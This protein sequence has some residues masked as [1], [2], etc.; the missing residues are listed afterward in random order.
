MKITE[1]IQERII[2]LRLLDERF[3]TDIAVLIE[4]IIDDGI[5]SDLSP[6]DIMTELE[7]TLRSLKD[8]EVI[9]D[10]EQERVI[11]SIIRKVPEME[12]A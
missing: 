8:D 9:A 11:K 7:D 12:N 1:K 6:D 3:D 5:T 10:P 2:D 4:S